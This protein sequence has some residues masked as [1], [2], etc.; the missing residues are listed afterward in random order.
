M[1]TKAIAEQKPNSIDFVLTDNI[2]GDLKRVAV[3]IYANDPKYHLYGRIIASAL[4]H[5][6]KKGNYNA[7][8]ID[9]NL[10]ITPL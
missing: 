1:P 3:L 7:E 10:C 6:F 8:I 9:D 2:I 4:A 5:G